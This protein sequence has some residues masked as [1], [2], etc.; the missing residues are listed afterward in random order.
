MAGGWAYDKDGKKIRSFP[1]DHGTDHMKNFIKAVRSQKREDL[2][3]DILEGQISSSLCIMANISYRVGT[4]MAQE[5]VRESIQANPDA[6]RMYEQFSEHIAVNGID[7]KTATVGPWLRLDLEKERIVTD[8]PT[9]ELIANSLFR[10][11]D[12]PPF[13]VPEQV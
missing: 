2:N 10:R 7:T 8:D 5:Q 4:A 3:A 13:V 9:A 1:R 12:R 11:H 6:L